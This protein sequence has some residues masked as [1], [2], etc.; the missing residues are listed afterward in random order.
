VFFLQSLRTQVDVLARKLEREKA[1]V[2]IPKLA[3]DILVAA[4]E[5]GRVT[6]RD[7][8]RLTG[9]NRNTI[10]VHLKALVQKRLLTREGKGK[11]TWYRP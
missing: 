6:V 10:K 9:A 2:A 7:I 5:Q 4:R 11:G 1:L 8:L 3:Q